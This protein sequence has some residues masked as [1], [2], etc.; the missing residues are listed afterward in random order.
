M[1][2]I[3]NVH[4]VGGTTH[5]HISSLKWKNTTTASVGESTRQ[6]LV[7]WL[8]VQGNEAIVRHGGASA[9]VGVVRPSNGPNYVRTYA[10]GIW[11]DNLLAL[12][13]Y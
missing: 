1:I 6:Q 12:P 13:R 2:E 5:E 8:S 3:T 11:T 4:M 10:D 9:F 7:D